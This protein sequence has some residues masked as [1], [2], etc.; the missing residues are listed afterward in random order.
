MTI[1]QVAFILF[2]YGRFLFQTALRGDREPVLRRARSRWS[3]R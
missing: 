3:S 1:I 2:L